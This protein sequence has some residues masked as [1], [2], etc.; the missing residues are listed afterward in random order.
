MALHCERRTL[1]LD[2]PLDLR[3]TLGHLRRG[4][5][6]P[7][8]RIERAEVWK[9]TRTVDGP[10]T[11]HLWTRGGRLEAEAWGP[12]A[13]STL[14][15]LPQFV[16]ERDGRGTFRPRHP[17]LRDLRRKLVGL[18]IGRTG[19]V[20]ESIV[21]AVL[22]QKVTGLEYRRAWRRLVLAFSEPAPGPVDLMLPAAPARLAAEP[23]EAWHPLGVER[24]RAEV[25]RELARHARRL[26]ETSAMPDREARSRLRAFPGVG[27][28]TVA[29]VAL[30][31]FGDA[32]A[33]S[34]GDYHV[35]H[36][37]SWGLA[38]ERRGSDERMLELL[39]PYRG[40]R[41]RVIRL[42]ELGFSPPGR[43]G[44]RLAPRVHMFD[45]A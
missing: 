29:E 20:V 12:G 23:Y 33:V 14:D 18:R 28:W 44:P 35:P 17:V 1:R 5:G 6:D 8:M 3:L 42:L 16:G 22:E 4:L 13:R 38:G 15:A 19:A 7:T 10:A 9:A 43:R 21:P 45:G 31:A 24:R 41:G 32:D 36:L 27:P 11:I 34:V 2:S 40:H 30:R 26:E 39:E 25:I 37:V